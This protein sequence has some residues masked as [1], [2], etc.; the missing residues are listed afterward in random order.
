MHETKQTLFPG[1]PFAQE[2]TPCP[3]CGNSARHSE[4]AL[5]DFLYGVPGEF[6]TGACT[7]C[8]LFYLSPRPTR[9]AIVHYYPASYVSYRR[10]IQDERFGLMRW[11]RR[12]KLVQRRQAVA[13]HA[14]RRPGRLLDVGCSTGLFLDEMRS[15]GWTVAGIEINPETAE[16]A[17]NRFQLPVTVGDLLE[18]DLRAQAFD[19]ITL[20]DV[21][22]HTFDPAAV[23]E[24]AWGLL[25]EGG[26]LALT[27]PSWE[28]LDRR[29][30]GRYWVGFDAPRH[31]HVFP[32]AVL[33]AMLHDTGFQVLE[34]RCQ[35]GGYFTFITSM[36][37]YLR[38]AGVK[39]GWRKV[40][41]KSMDFPGAR[42]PFVPVFWLMEQLGMD[43]L[44]FV[45]AQKQQ[46][47]TI[48]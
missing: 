30:F 46:S 9:T 19:L 45:V 39:P 6:I 10:A 27:L 47:N 20:F 21:L 48:G 8:G 11:M 17:R 35:F 40:I 2:T 38:G 26:L 25:A 14:P 41:E 16:Y 7:A 12:R 23:L 42:L 44:R 43:G 1:A 24:K 33:T 5:Q 32:N 15:A 3:R 36:R 31:L 18:V 28:S 22:E 29:L 4:Y 13:K 37:S 34:N